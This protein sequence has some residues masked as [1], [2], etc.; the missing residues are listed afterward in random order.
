MSII[1]LWINSILLSLY[2]L[3][4]PKSVISV[5]YFYFFRRTANSCLLESASLLTWQEMTQSTPQAYFFLE[6]S[7]QIRKQFP[8]PCY[9]KTQKLKAENGMSLLVREDT[10]AALLLS[11]LQYP[12][13]QSLDLLLFITAN[14][15]CVID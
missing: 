6:W 3:I 15:T 7:A 1:T 13:D 8:V 10:D 5:L 12:T 2:F 14:Y 4:Q 11:F 9:F